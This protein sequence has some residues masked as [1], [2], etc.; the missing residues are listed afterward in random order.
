MFSPS[1]AVAA[2]DR[3]IHK[4]VVGRLDKPQHVHHCIFHRPGMETGVERKPTWKPKPNPDKAPAG[5]F[6]QETRMG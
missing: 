2:T 5:A 1:S 3:K 4:A 6:A